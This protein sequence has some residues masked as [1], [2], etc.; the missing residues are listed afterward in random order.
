MKIRHTSVWHLDSA[1]Y[2]RKHCFTPCYPHVAV[3]A[4]KTI[5]GHTD[6]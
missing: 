5:G 4:G 3:I 1:F 2:D 6:E